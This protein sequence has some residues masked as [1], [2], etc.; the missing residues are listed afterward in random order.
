L[1]DELIKVDYFVPEDLSEEEFES[2]YG[3]DDDL[4]DYCY[5]KSWTETIPM[6]LIFFM[7]LTGSYSLALIVVT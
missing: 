3:L 1:Y 6:F 5:Y 4:Y 7:F 2:V